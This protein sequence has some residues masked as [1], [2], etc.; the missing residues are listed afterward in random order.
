MLKPLH[1]EQEAMHDAMSRDNDWNES[2]QTIGGRFDSGG[3]E[4]GGTDSRST[5]I[6]R[7]QRHNP[8]I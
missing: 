5:C 3:N 8:G 2:N 7:K 4:I 1:D 6:P